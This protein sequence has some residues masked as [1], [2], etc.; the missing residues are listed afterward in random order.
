MKKIFLLLLSLSAFGAQAECVEP[1]TPINYMPLSTAHSFC[2]DKKIK[3]IGIGSN[4]SFRT[5]I[6]GS[7]S[8]LITP[9]E[10]GVFTNMVIVFEDGERKEFN[11]L[12]LDKAKVEF[13]SFLKDELATKT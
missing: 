3:Q 11:L 7:N 12:S 1:S 13:V 9:L 10:S 6:E 4:I 8:V 5:D 2:F